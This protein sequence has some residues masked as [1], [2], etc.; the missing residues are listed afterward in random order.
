MKIYKYFLYEQCYFEEA[1]HLDKTV[2]VQKYFDNNFVFSRN[3]NGE[4]VKNTFSY[5]RSNI[6]K[7]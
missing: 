4:K 6:V 7:N 3:I 2:F 1:I 5:I